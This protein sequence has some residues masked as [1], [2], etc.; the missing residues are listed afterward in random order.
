MSQKTAIIG[1][2]PLIYMKNKKFVLWIALL[3][4]AI[5]P[6]FAQNAN[7]FK[8]DG[9]GTITKYDGWDNKIVIPAKIGNE[10]ITA[11][12]DGA[13]KNMGLT[14]VT[15]PAGIKRIG[16][17][18]FAGNKLTTLTIPANVTISGYAFSRNQLTGLTIGNNCFIYTN[19]FQGNNNLKNI[20]LGANIH[21][22]PEAFSS[23][24]FFDYNGNSRK[25]GTYDVTVE[26]TQKKEGD[27]AFLETKYGAVI[28]RY[29]GSE[30]NR[31][32]IPGKLG[33]SA[34]KGISEFAFYNRSISRMQLP[35]SLIF[36][37][38]KAFSDNQLTSVTIP[39]SVFFIG[40]GAF[41]SNKLTNVTI[42]NSVTSIGS[43][44]FENNEL[45]SV[46]IP[47][48]V[49]YIGVGAFSKN[50]L[51][52]VTIGNNVTYIDNSAF[53]NN[54]LTNITIPNSVTYIGGGFEMGGAFSSNNLT[55]VTIGNSVDYIGYG[56]FQNN[57]LTSVTIP[58]SVTYIG[59]RA[60]QNCKN[61][62]SVT[63][64][65]IIPSNNFGN[66]V[67]GYNSN[68]KEKYLEGGIGTYTRESG[69]DTW[70]KK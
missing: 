63:F 29:S 57:E 53:Y 62:T 12:G 61:L 10:Q 56:A 47:N 31:L 3:F 25:A 70:T 42:G 1:K 45:T 49:T 14:S 8:T 6:V 35:D 27:Y 15:L 59:D 33:A 38:A 19:V 17:E 11:I 16:G 40:H 50:K 43:E 18:A 54:Q 65:A 68:L 28:T 26:Y 52:N 24:L 41:Y 46:T 21:F 64:Q 39:N 69:S 13:F 32:I 22:E 5:I 23:Y 58:D 2:K 51:T 9:K 44:A 7:D 20:T 36:I 37:N 30:V 66:S 60:F 4:I 55:S 67:F 48:S 34:V